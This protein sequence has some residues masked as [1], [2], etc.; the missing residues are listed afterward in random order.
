QK[1]SNDS[2]LVVVLLLK[3]LQISISSVPEN[4]HKTYWNQKVEELLFPTS[5]RWE[6]DFPGYVTSY[7]LKDI[8]TFK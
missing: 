8:H 2:V 1:P 7:I 6:F 3:L 5:N 4:T